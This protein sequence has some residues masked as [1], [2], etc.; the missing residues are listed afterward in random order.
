M[1]LVAARMLPFLAGAV[2]LCIWL[3]PRLLD[4]AARWPISQ[5][6]LTLAIVITLLLAWSA[7]A[8]GLVAAITGAFLTGLLFARTSHRAEIEAGISQLADSFLVPIFFASIGLQINLLQQS[9]N[10][11]LFT[12]LI[13]AVAIV[14]KLLGGGAGAR[15]AGFSNR[16]SLRIGAG[17]V[18]RGEL[19][20]IVASVGLS[21]GIIGAEL[22]AAAVLMVL[23]TA[24][25]TPPL[26]RL[27]F[28][29][30][31]VINWRRPPVDD[32]PMHGGRSVAAPPEDAQFVPKRSGGDRRTT[33]T[34]H[35]RPPRRRP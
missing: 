22:F 21:S 28:R 9:G 1:A 32:R 25:A 23:A 5:P 11:F 30:R 24:L 6:V 35:D 29:E 13:C 8:V 4:R 2:L 20:L 19:G 14:A 33:T 34:T 12:L 26:L 18:A 17:M 10:L 7:E 31:P 27:T 16:E 3:F 15:L